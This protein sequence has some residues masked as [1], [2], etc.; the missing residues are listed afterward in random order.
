[1]TA[2]VTV[3]VL[4]NRTA[5]LEGEVRNIVGAEKAVFLAH[6]LEE[7]RQHAVE[8]DRGVAVAGDHAAKGVVRKESD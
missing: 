4:W 5:S 7:L 3:E 8:A 1:M 6:G 2:S